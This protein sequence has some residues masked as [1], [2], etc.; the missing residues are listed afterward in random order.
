MYDI[1]ANMSLFPQRW[2]WR[3]T[4]P[5]DLLA[6]IATI[7]AEKFESGDFWGGV[8]SMNGG[9]RLISDDLLDCDLKPG[10]IALLTSF[11]VLEHVTDLTGIFERCYDL[12]AP[13]GISYHFIDL[14]DHR[15]YRG[16]GAYGP[17]SFLFEAQAPPN[18]N[19]LRAP[20]FAEAALAVGFELLGDRR[21]A[22]EMS[23]E[24]FASLVPPFSSMAPDDVVITKQHL[25]LRKPS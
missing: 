21:I 2:C 11:A 9:V 24:D 12:L 8:E 19:R 7:D 6:R 15:S 23:P 17:Y 22:G 16:D 18:M 25:T 3:D 20:Q 14:A 13:G 10:S 1:L 4:D 5:Q